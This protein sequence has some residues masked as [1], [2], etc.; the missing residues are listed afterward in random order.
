MPTAPAPRRLSGVGAA[1]AGVAL[2]GGVLAALRDKPGELPVYVRAAVQLSTG[3]SIYDPANVPAFSYPPAFALATLPLVPLSDFA[4]RWAWWSMNLG[5]LLAVLA[6]IRAA[7]LPALLAGRTDGA[8]DAAGRRRLWVWGGLTAALAVRFVLSPLQYQSHDLILLALMTAAA[9]WWTRGRNGRAGAAAGLAAACK[10][11]P[12]LALPFFLLR[13]RWAAAGTM[14]L[15]IAAASLAP[16]ALYPNPDG[17]PWAL[18]W[19]ERFVAPTSL[20]EAPEVKHAWKP[21]NPL[22]QSLAGTIARLTTDPP[23]VEIDDAGVATPTDWVAVTVAPTSAATRKALTLGVQAAVLCW[24]AWCAWRPAADDRHAAPFRRVPEPDEARHADALAPG[25]RCL[26]ELSLTLCGMLLLSP[27]SSTQ[28]FC[29]LLPGAAVIAARLLIAPRDGWN[30]AAAT[31]L[32][33]VGSL[34]AKDLIGDAACEV[35]RSAGG[36][37][38]CTLMVLWACGRLLANDR[39]AVR[40]MKQD[41]PAKASRSAAAPASSPLPLARAA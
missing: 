35:V 10:A 6:V 14:L 38:A 32:F 30:R 34:P 37:T 29:F 21:W 22:N 17:G 27:M 39:R 2:L 41:H 12:L 40:A 33:V 7:V 18:T 11:T 23:A 31:C 1:V 25:L 28:H 16:D 24:L 19:V 20:G 3:Q 4:R 8:I 36:H 26:S 13:R 5:L 15:A 9:V